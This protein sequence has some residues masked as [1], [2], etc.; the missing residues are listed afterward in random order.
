MFKCSL[1]VLIC[2]QQ[3]SSIP[4][5]WLICHRSQ[6]WTSSKS[7]FGNDEMQQKR[8]S[9]CS[10]VRNRKENFFRSNFLLWLCKLSTQKTFPL[11]FMKHLPLIHLTNRLTSMTFFLIFLF[12]PFQ[13][14]APRYVYHQHQPKKV[15]RI[16]PV[17][18]CFIAKDNFREFQEYSPCRTSEFLPLKLKLNIFERYEIDLVQW[19]RT[20]FL[21]PSH[22]KLKLSKAVCV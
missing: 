20:I 5:L 11:K 14:C 10:C 16:E 7:L 8:H 21:P 19:R 3:L 4:C 12:I 6:G 1:V 13:A 18:T 15:E 9:C 17:G 2:Y 22:V